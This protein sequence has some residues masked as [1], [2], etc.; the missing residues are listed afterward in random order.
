MSL[1]TEPRKGQQVLEWSLGLGPGCSNSPASLDESL[2]PIIQERDRG[3]GN[4]L[5]V[6]WLRTHL[7]MLE[8]Q[9]PSLGQSHMPW[10]NKARVPQLMSQCSRAQELQR[11][12]P[13]AATP[14][15]HVS[16]AHALQQEK[17]P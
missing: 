1:Q 11:L 16:R 4:S 17:P 15:V 7:P 6:K 3:G 14:E 5:V 13:R 9:V 10:N 12:S 8:T 2:S